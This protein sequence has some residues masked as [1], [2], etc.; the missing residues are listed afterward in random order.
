[1]GEDCT[2]S[3]RTPEDPA[4]VFI[5]EFLAGGREILESR[6]DLGGFPSWG[7][8]DGILWRWAPDLRRSGVYGWWIGS[9]VDYHR[10]PASESD[11]SFLAPAEMDRRYPERPFVEQMAPLRTVRS[12]V[13]IRGQRFQVVE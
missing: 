2:W 3:E 6:P 7:A 5:T 13:V 9:E 1:M 12:G 10:R 11:I 8:P 4:V